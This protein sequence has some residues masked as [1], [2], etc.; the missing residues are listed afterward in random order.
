MNIRLSVLVSLPVLIGCLSSKPLPL[1]LYQLTS[2][3]TIWTFKLVNVNPKTGKEIMARVQ[4]RLDEIV[5]VADRYNS[6]GTIR[7]LSEAGKE[8]PIPVSRDVALMI[9]TAREM[10]K[11]TRGKFDITVGPLIDLWKSAAQTNTLPE[12]SEL[13]QAK[14]NV[15][16][17]AIHVYKKNN[18]WYCY[19]DNKKIVIDLGGIAKGYGLDCAGRIIDREGINNYLIDAGGEIRCKGHN[20]N[21]TSWTIGVRDPSGT[22]ADSIIS[23]M[24]SDHTC[25]TSGVYNR[26]T[27]IKGKQYHHIIDPDTGWPAA[28]YQSVTV[29]LPNNMTSGM[30]ADCL[31]TGLL[32]LDK[33]HGQRICDTYPGSE[34]LYILP[35]GEIVEYNSKNS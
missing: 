14:N 31:S 32:M 19:S 11:L 12:P 26:F 13:E 23:R 29:I 1:F 30:R 4:Q 15:D 8:N 24:L 16:Y 3:D 5:A 27:V 18:Q 20:Q 21:G 34:I 25:S 9:A 35:D 6:T 22:A 17:A 2:M 33:Q 10:S 28:Y 7:E